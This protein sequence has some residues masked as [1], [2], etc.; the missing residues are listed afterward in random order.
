MVL[1]A[2]PLIGKPTGVG[3]FVR[4][5]FHSV[6]GV[7]GLQVDAY[8]LTLRG[9]EQLRQVLPA[10]VNHPHV[11]MPA[12]ALLK[13]WARTAHP[14]IDRWVGAS[15]VVHGTN[16]VVPPSAT[17]A[18]LV[19]VHDLA[20]IHYPAL[21]E[22]QS[23]AYPDLVRKAVERGAHVHTM[24]HSVGDEVVDFLDVHPGRVHVIP[25]G[26]SGELVAEVAGES[27]GKTIAGFDRYVLAVGTIEPRKDYVSLLQAFAQL[28]PECTDVGLVIAGMRGWGSEAFDEELDRLQ[29]GD[30]V[31]TLG[32]VSDADRLA[33]LRGASLLAFPSIYE[34]FGLPPLEAM[35]KGVPVVATAAGAVPEV[36]GNAALVVGLKDIEGFASAMRDVLSGPEL[37]AALVEAGHARAREFSWQ[38]FGVE[39][40]AL[41]E[42]LSAE[43]KHR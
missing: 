28:G 39:M 40:K 12:G 2:T 30:R 32:Y 24:S 5:L 38:R 22:P 18:T 41:Y 26:L 6:V 33:L 31:R 42:E 19:T 10:G 35:Q 15:D 9:F 14:T 34:G 1:D 20:A 3:M 29:L 13:T 11:P 21:C 25:P 36:V 43:R 37:A 8:A 16:F 7:E 27:D 23:R 4:G 17:A